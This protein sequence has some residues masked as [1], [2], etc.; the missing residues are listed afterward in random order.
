METIPVHAASKIV[1][2][3]LIYLPVAICLTLYVAHTLFKNAQIFM[4][5]IFHGKEEIARSTNRLFEIGFYLLNLGFALL[6]LKIDQDVFNYQSLIEI[7]SKKVGGFTIY[8][9]LMLFFNLYLFFRGRKASRRAE[10]WQQL[11][12]PANPEGV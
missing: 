8:L 6:I 7:L 4:F 3:Y 2:A 9:G 10:Q 12:N 11:N 1:T 5:D